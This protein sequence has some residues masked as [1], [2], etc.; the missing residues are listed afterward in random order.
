MKTQ[1][2]EDIGHSASLTLVPSGKTVHPTVDQEVQNIAQALATAPD[3]PRSASGGVWRQKPAGE[4]TVPQT[5]QPN[6]QPVTPPPVEEAPV[7]A[8]EP[9]FAANVPANEMASR[10]PLFEFTLPWPTT[11]VPE[12]PQLERTAPE[13]SGS[14]NLLWGLCM[15]AAALVIL[16]G[17]WFYEERKDAEALALVADDVKTQPQLV[18]K[19]VQAP[20]AAPASVPV[21][22]P[23][24]L[25]KPEP[26][27]APAVGRETV[28][29]QP[30][31][32]R[33][34]QPRPA[35][36]LPKRVRR[37]EREQVVARAPVIPTERKAEQES[38]TTAMLK[39]CKEHGYQAAQC[40]KRACSMTKYGFVCRGK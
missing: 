17:L 36:S 16:A 19:A 20:P 13:P 25:L 30:K 24:V 21:V 40:I 5:P 34:A 26:A 7:L 27:D 6:Q 29:A 18:V 15:L 9:S 3:R 35:R 23:L 38:T 31:P 32:E 11:P 8:A 39:A 14:R 33:V 12:L 2:L 22:P 10:D 37:T 1:L 4:P 28:Q